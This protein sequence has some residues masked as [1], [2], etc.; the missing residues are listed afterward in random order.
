ML[1]NIIQILILI[2]SAGA[3]FLV[4]RTDQYSKYGHILGL[5][6]QPLWMYTTIKNEQWGLVLLTLFYTYCWGMGIYNHWYKKKII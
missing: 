6:G 1:D 5:V 2:L 4:S 3:I